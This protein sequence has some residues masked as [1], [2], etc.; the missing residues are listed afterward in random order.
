M[1][2]FVF[3]IDAVLAMIPVFIILASVSQISGAGSLFF[4]SYVLGSERI[5]QDALEVIMQRG[6]LEELNQTKINSTLH[7]LVPSQ[8]NFSFELEY[9]GSVI[10]NST[11][12]SVSAAKE[13]ASARRLVLLKLYKLLGIVAEVSH[14][15]ST[16]AEELCPRQGNKPP[17]YSTSF[18][19][20]P[21][22]LAAFDYWIEGRAPEK[23]VTAWYYISNSSLD[24][25]A[26]Q[27]STDWE[28]FLSANEYSAKKQLPE[29]PAEPSRGG[30][31]ME[32]TNYLYI[33]VAA[34]PNRYGSFYVIKAPAN[35]ASSL[36]SYENAIK[37]DFAWAT[38]KVSG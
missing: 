8:Y 23:G 15:G 10:I 2:A 24:C 6:D 25:D 4:Q 12:G 13:V 30:R 7:S 36:I 9:N 31:L 32:G 29:Y 33:K 5:A 35:T 37:R 11:R 16:L 17:I 22:D 14:S 27:G 19:I 20:D 3:T 21:G 1:R 28:Q 26:L 38:L 34:N 18:T